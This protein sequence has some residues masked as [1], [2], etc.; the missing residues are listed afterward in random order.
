MLTNVW[1][2]LPSFILSSLV[3]INKFFFKIN[4]FHFIHFG[5]VSLELSARACGFTSSF[6][7]SCSSSAATCLEVL[8]VIL[9]FFSLSTWRRVPWDG[10]GSPS[11]LEKAGTAFPIPE[12]Q[13]LRSWAFSLASVSA[14]VGYLA[15][16]WAKVPWDGFGSPS[17][18]EN[19]GTAFPIPELQFLRS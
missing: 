11:L 6:I 12:L 4:V 14:I 3:Y 2:H 5:S 7:F 18:L 1:I 17:L 10:F 9:S 8:V 16:N 19:A 15:D 13:F